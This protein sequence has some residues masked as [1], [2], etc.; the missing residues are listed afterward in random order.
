VVKA[1]CV[2]LCQVAGVIFIWQVMLRSS[3]IGYC[4]KP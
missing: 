1:G 4:E 2:H 3:E